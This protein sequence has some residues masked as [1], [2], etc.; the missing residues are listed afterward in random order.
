MWNKNI[1]WKNGSKCFTKDVR[2]AVRTS[3]RPKTQVDLLKIAVL[4]LKFKK[5]KLK[6]EMNSN[7]EVR[8][9]DISKSKKY[10]VT[11]DYSKNQVQIDTAYVLQTYLLT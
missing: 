5:L 7:F 9:L 11:L 4:C 10:R 2:Q 8:K 6:F 3:Y 1:C